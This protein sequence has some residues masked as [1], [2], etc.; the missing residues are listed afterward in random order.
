MRSKF[1]G[2]EISTGHISDIFGS[3]FLERFSYKSF[4]YLNDESEFD[5][6]VEKM[7]KLQKLAYLSCLGDIY[8]RFQLSVTV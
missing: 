8:V 2:H 5:L 3:Q 7:S 1:R 4:T 6:Q